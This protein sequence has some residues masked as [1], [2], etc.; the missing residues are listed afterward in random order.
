MD[1]LGEERNSAE[2]RWW[3]VYTCWKQEYLKQK[4]DQNAL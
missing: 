1:A 4:N 2:L 3:S